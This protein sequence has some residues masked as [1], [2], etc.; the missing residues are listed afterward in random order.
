[1][2]RNMRKGGVATAICSLVQ[3][4]QRLN[5]AVIIR[6]AQATSDSFSF[7]VSFYKFMRV[8]AHVSVGMNLAVNKPLN[9]IHVM[10]EYDI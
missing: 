5:K 7:N 1:M 10:P 9:S 6:L 4:F 2:L 8:P 3:S